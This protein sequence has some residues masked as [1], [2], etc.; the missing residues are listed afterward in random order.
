MRF[1]ASRVVLA[2]AAAVRYSS[3]L[4]VRPRVSTV[5][6]TRTKKEIP[7]MEM[8]LNANERRGGIYHWNIK[9][10]KQ[11]FICR[12]AA[13]IYKPASVFETALSW[14]QGNSVVL[15]FFSMLLTSSHFLRL[16]PIHR[17]SSSNAAQNNGILLNRQTN[18]CTLLIF[19]FIKTFLK[20]LKRLL[21]VS[22]I[23]PSS[24]SL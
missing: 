11:M 13:A 19:L 4:C 10:V 22:I 16:G 18:T 8:R 23:R 17:Q 12:V 20:F 2:T 24:G 5:R 15:T 6:T 3:I 9:E 1:S 21:H 7:H 14:S